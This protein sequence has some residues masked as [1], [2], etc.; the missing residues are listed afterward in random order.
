MKNIK[1]LYLII[2]ILI[3]TSHSQ[4][5]SQCAC[6]AGA[7]IGSSNGDYN[8]GIL[9]L[10]KNQWV[11]ETY[12]DYRTIKEGGAPDE[13]EKL[14]TSMF[15][16]ST[17]LRFG[18]NKNITVSALLPYVFL[19]TNNGNDKGLGDVDLFATIK[20]LSKNKF[21]IA[22]QTGL[23]LPTGTRKPSAFDNTTVIVGSGSY[24]P[25]IGV[26]VSKSWDKLA[27]QGNALYKHTTKGFDDNYYSSLSV[28]NIFL[29]YS[30]IGDANNC[31]IDSMKKNNNTI[32]WSVFG[33]YYG[34]W[35]DKIKE[36][37]LIDENSGYYS[38]FL[39]LGT[40]LSYKKISF[41]ITA[42]L[43]IISNMN[44]LQN[45]PGFR[46]RLGLIKSF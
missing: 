11:A 21:N 24:D 22:L 39:N 20:L 25:M 35:L 33:G 36:D 4:S 30:I 37:N 29:S 34:E 17:G 18:L 28:Q 45:A 9:T 31:S 10:N 2:T 46:I 12:G 15:I 7:G 19:K 38:G 16:N 42:S 23:E 40:N 13:E 1:G 41:P 44:G 32:S 8:N 5:F 3:I 26:I 27:I 6:C 14:L 43:P